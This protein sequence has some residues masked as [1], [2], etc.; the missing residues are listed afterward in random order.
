MIFYYSITRRPSSA[1][2]TTIGTRIHSGFQ[3][4]CLR[5]LIYK[6]AQSH[7]LASTFSKQRT[8]NQSTSLIV[9]HFVCSLQT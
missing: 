7:T 5:A 2:T 3:T 1:T 4:K 8:R 9:P 6:P